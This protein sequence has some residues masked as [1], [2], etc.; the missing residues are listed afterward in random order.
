MRR[1]TLKTA[2]IAAVPLVGI[3][4]LALS[5]FLRGDP[6]LENLRRRESAELRSLQAGGEA[7][8]EGDPLASLSQLRLARR[9]AS[10]GNPSAMQAARDRMLEHKEAA[11]PILKSAIYRT[12]EEPL[13][14]MECVGLLADLKESAAGTALFEV[15]GDRS[16]EERFRGVA[17]ARLAGRPRPEAFPVLKR[18]YSDEPSFGNRP[19]L[20]KA[21]GGCTQPETT[22]LLRE[23]AAEGQAPS[24]RIQAL[25]SLSSRTADP[26]VV[27][28]L[29]DALFKSS[30]QNVR[31][32]ALASLARS[33]SNEADEL[34]NQI[35]E[36]TS[37]AEPIRREAE[38]WIER[39]KRR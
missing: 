21:I 36:N 14:R 35:R 24:L 37:I 1:P 25:E 13:L 20:V 30:E 28:T 9:K 23:A 16:L 32:A 18:I 39:R 17:L 22:A 2:L 26:E 5:T 7:G 19:L 8:E 11:V 10:A 12:E 33:N 38:S 4:A 27:K 31:M 6:S 34:L 15:M 3:L 29:R